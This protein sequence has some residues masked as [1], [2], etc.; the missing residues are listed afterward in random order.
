MFLSFSLISCQTNNPELITH[1]VDGDFIGSE[2]V[3]P[4]NTVT[5][6]RMYYQ[7]QYDEVVTG[8]DN[9]VKNVSKEVDRYHNYSGI[10][11]LKTINDSCGTNQEIVISNEL[12]DVI[13]FFI[14]TDKM[15]KKLVFC[16]VIYDLISI[17]LFIFII[18]II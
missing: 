8:F 13:L 5:Q 17:I 2:F 1:I 3:F 15:N 6:L 12:F 9:I 11:N 16:C 14:N 18:E 7:D 10:N 4:M